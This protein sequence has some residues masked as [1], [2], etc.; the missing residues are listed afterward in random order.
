MKPSFYTSKKL[1]DALE[2]SLDY[3]MRV[4][5]LIILDNKT[6]Q[7]QKDIDKLIDI[8]RQIILYTLNNLIKAAKLKAI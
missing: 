2:V 8:D 6:L 3:L 4:G 5:D 1:D 7:R